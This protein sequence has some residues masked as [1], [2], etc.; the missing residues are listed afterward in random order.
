MKLIKEVKAMSAW[1]G[2]TLTMLLSN[3]KKVLNQYLEDDRRARVKD[4]DLV[5]NLP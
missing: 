1:D 4:K 2:F 5:C 3:S